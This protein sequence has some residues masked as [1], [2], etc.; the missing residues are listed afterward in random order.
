MQEQKKTVRVWDLPTR[1]F[2]WALV[3]TLVMLVLL[4]NL[5]ETLWHTRFGY[6]LLSLLL[7]RFTWGL[8]GGHWSRF[9]QFPPRIGS[10]L[11]YLRGRGT[12]ESVGHNPLGAWSVY[13][14]LLALLLQVLTGMSSEDEITFAGPFANHLSPTVVE[15]ANLYHQSIGKLLVFGL[16]GLHIAAIVYYQKT[17][18]HKALVQAMWTGDKDLASLQSTD[19]QALANSAETTETI[20]SSKDNAATRLLAVLVYAVCAAVVWFLVNIL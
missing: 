4:I 3:L 16:I 12:G 2:H 5:D 8:I 13:A 14:L 15:F 20:E 7:F 17:K 9:A 6:F 10:A 11:A 18:K 1:V 19:G